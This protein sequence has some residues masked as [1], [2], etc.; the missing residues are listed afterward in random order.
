MRLGS[1]PALLVP[2]PGSDPIIGRIEK[3]AELGLSVMNLAFREPGQQAPDYQ[4]RVAETAARLGIELRLMGAGGEIGSADPEARKVGVETTIASLLE[5][6]RNTGITFAMTVCRPMSHNRWVPVPPMDERIDMIGENLAKIADGVAAAGIVLGL[7]NH[8]DYRGYECAAMLAKA[9]RPNM[10]AQFDT[11]NPFTVFEEPVDA[12]RA[13]AKWTVSCHLKD[14]KVTPL[15]GAPVYGSVAESA[16]LG[17]GHV[18]NVKICQILQAESP[19]PKNLALMFE[20]LSL[21]PE[22]DRDEFIRI[23]IEWCRDKLAAF[24]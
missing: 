7:E 9:N 10:L 21:A 2:R 4:K 13:M 6:N 17:Q 1:V 8:C 12:A 5:V 18:D 19:D 24:L 23:C 16:P 3:A 22:V 11:G 15:R 20:P 14:V